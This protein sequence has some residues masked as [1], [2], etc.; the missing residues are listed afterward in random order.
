MLAV[1]QGLSATA[2]SYLPGPQLRPEPAV[3]QGSSS[4][5][6]PAPLGGPSLARTSRKLHG[7]ASPSRETVEEPRLASAPRAS[8]STPSQ[9]NARGK[10][11]PESK[12][13]TLQ[14][15][16]PWTHRLD[17]SV[18]IAQRCPE[19]QGARF[20]VY[21]AL[22]LSASIDI[23]IKYMSYHCQRARMDIF[24]FVFMS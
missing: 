1:A 11:K 5:R 12:K 6:W 23:V 19:G 18:G 10:E 4:G 8:V 16:L 13:E 2:G 7:L 9:Q 15:I 22:A 21:L 14:R 3:P 24:A 17:G 20:C